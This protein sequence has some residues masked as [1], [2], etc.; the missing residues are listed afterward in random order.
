MYHTPLQDIYQQR[1]GCTFHRLHVHAECW[2]HRRVYLLERIEIEDRIYY[3][4]RN[5]LSTSYQDREAVQ[6][7][8]NKDGVTESVSTAHRQGE[9]GM[10]TLNSP[11]RRSTVCL[12]GQRPLPPS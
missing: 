9:E 2:G 4:V 6:C 3:F 8:I 10:R 5:R 1:P 11:G 12:A 7:S